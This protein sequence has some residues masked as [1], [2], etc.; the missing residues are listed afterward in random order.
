MKRWKLMNEAG[1]SD[2]G[3]G[4]VDEVVDTKV[5]QPPAEKVEDV[6]V[7]TKVIDKPEQKA[8]EKP[9]EKPEEKKDEVKPTWPND[10]REKASKGDEKVLKRLGR[11]ASPEAAIDALIAAQNKI[12]SGEYKTALPKNATPEQLS[13]W[14]KENGIPDKPEDYELKFD[15]GLVIGDADK[16]LV[17]NFL[18]VAH[19]R[20][21][22]SESVKSTIEWYYQ[23]QERMTNERLDQDEKEARET[24]ST[25]AQEYGGEYKR[26]MTAVENLLSTF[27]D[28][29]RDLFK[30]GR[31]A[32]G[33]AIFNEPQVIRAFVSMAREVNPASTVVSAGAG[34]PSKTIEDE[35]KSIESKM[36]TKAYTSDE[37]MQSRYRELVDAREKM[38]KRA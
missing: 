8:E 21:L 24:I 33:K 26:N 20:N 28:E 2:G 12:S 31:L 27:P 36:G 25:L 7:D 30:S 16:A 4:V 5:V 17:D 29:V 9:S 13:D 19:G 35:I 38:Q 34:D 32:N 3:G 6:V 23:E 18:K 11:Y 15:S 10:W 14:R 1:E 37:K 22:D